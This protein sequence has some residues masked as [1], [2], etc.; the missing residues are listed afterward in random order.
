M[1]DDNRK[2]P[3]VE[4]ISVEQWQ[5]QLNEHLV[6]EVFAV[7]AGEEGNYG[8]DFGDTVRFSFLASFVATLVYQALSEKVDAGVADLGT[9]TEIT[10][11]RYQDVKEAIQNA[12]AS[13]FEG[14]MNEWSGGEQTFG[15]EI[16]PDPE[17]TNK[18]AC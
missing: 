15:C 12:V 10:N 3:K 9:A 18:L 7:I 14:A 4:T 1:N 17:P 6:R 5:T 16:S 2:P 8:K 13:G 11:M